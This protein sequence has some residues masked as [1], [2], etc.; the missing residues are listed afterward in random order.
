MQSAQL[1]SDGLATRQIL[2]PS[3]VSRAW[4]LLAGFCAILLL[5]GYLILSVVFNKPNEKLLVHKSASTICALF[6][7][8]IAYSASVVLAI[9]Q[10]HR[11]LFLLRSV[12]MPYMIIN[13]LSLFNVLFNILGRDLFPLSALRVVGIGLPSAFSV[14]YGIAAFLV[15]REYGPSRGHRAEDGTPLLSE[16][17]M[18][19][20]QLLRLLQERNSAAPSPDLIQN[21]YR[22]DLPTNMEPAQKPW[23]RHM[24]PP[25][26]P[27][28]RGRV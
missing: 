25:R 12:F 16:E 10:R 24:A 4:K 18:Q 15:Y 5:L 8:A 9:A 21:T 6:F 3:R 14:I 23:N 17:E 13:L 1:E 26:T 19:R 27:L 28:G 11:K 22:L 20:R 7:I 2:N